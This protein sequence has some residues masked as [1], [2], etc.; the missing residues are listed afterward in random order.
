MWIGVG[1]AAALAVATIAM[2]A[3][4]PAAPARADGSP[5]RLAVLPA[6]HYP[7][8]AEAAA[9]A[10]RITDG[11]TGELVRIGRLEIVSRTS[12]R[13]FGGERRSVRD[14][15]EALDADW[16]IEATGHR[17]AGGVRVEVRLVDPRRDRKVWVEGFAGDAGNL[18]DLDRRVAAAIDVEVGRSAARGAAGAR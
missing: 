13:Q 14:I 11:V 3:S 7:A 10:E 9:L 6:T 16:I 18:G 15:A 4:R 5:P 12:T 1:A 17:E 8:D 2:L